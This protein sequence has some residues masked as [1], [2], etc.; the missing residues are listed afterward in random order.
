MSGGDPPLFCPHFPALRIVIRGCE[1]AVTVR[2]RSGSHLGSHL[3]KLL[4]SSRFFL[5]GMGPNFCLLAGQ[6]AFWLLL[7]PCGGV[8][9]PE[10]FFRMNSGADPGTLPPGGRNSGLCTDLGQELPAPGCK[11]YTLGLGY[12]GRSGAAPKWLNSWRRC[13]FCPRSLNSGRGCGSAKFVNGTSWTQQNSG[14]GCGSCHVVAELRHGVRIL[15]IF[16]RIPG[17]RGPDP[18]VSLLGSQD[19]PA[20]PGA[21]QGERIPQAF[22]SAA[23]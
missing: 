16:R 19:L 11:S 22:R 21:V 8:W 20:A 7:P 10:M 4:W 5:C 14:Q 17:E 6:A 12:W 18:D 9:F 13:R 1:P 3:G 2:V 15:P 23:G